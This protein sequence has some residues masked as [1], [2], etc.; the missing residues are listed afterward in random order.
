MR[1]TF[2][3]ACRQKR[4]FVPKTTV[5]PASNCGAIVQD[6]RRD[7]IQGGLGESEMIFYVVHGLSLKKSPCRGNQRTG[8]PWRDRGKRMTGK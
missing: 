1:S 4:Y 2:F 5:C 6:H 7:A 8:R 3:L